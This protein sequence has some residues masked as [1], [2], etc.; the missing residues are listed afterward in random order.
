MTRVAITAAV[1]VMVASL[2]MSSVIQTGGWIATGVGAIIIVAAAGVLTRLPRLP[3]AVVATF[4]VLIALVPMLTRPGWPDRSAALVILVITALSATGARPFRGFAV[5]ASYV[6]A[7]LL[8]LNVTFAHAASYGYLIPSDNSIQALSRLWHAAF[9]EFQF[10]PPVQDLPAVS[11]VTAAGIGAVAIAVDILAVRLRR[12]AV[13]GLPLL[14]LFSVPVASNLKSF[15]VPQVIV[16]AASLASYLALLSA[17]GRER[18]RMWGRLV[19]FRHVQSADESGSGPDTRELSASGRRIGLAAVCL[20]IVIPVILPSMRVR[21]VFATSADGSGHSG[22]GSSAGLSPLLN[23]SHVLEGKPQPVL[24]YTT[25]AEDPSQQYF[26]VYAVNYS[27]RRNAWLPPSYQNFRTVNGRQLPWAAP[28]AGRTTTVSKVTTA[29][30]ISKDDTGYAV[31]PMPYAPHQLTVGDSGWRETAGT[32]MVFNPGMAMANLHYTVQSNE[33][34]PQA[35]EIKTAQPPADIAAQYGTYTGPD[36]K[37]LDA[38]AVRETRGAGTQLQEAQDLEKWFQSA[39]FKYSLKPNLPQTSWLLPFLNT[40]RRGFCVQFAQAFAIL[41]RVLG[42]PARI[43]IGYTGGSPGPGKTWEVT[44]ADAHAWPELYFYG[45]GWLRFEP[46]PSGSHGPGTAVQPVYAG[47]NSGGAGS[48]G[49]TTQPG[50][51]NGSQGQQGASGNHLRNIGR[52]VGLA[53]SGPASAPKRASSKLWLAI[54]IPAALFLLIAWPALTRLL[55][56]RRRWL[57][58]SGDAAIA[59]AA[60]REL[61]DDLADYGLGGMPGETPR[62]VARRVTRQARLDESAT[63]AVSMLAAAEERARYARLPDP[64]AGLKPAVVTVRRAVAASVPRQQRLRAR[65]LPASTMLAAR[66]LV[67]RVSE[68]LGWLDSSWPALQRQLRRTRQ[69]E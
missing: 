30:T 18:L 61:T 16:F 22:G 42:I 49:G 53:G 15:G 57:S 35:A 14:L 34:N 23:L 65:L 29:I 13:A 51:G 37:Q 41:A 28:G 32:L 52:D 21:D 69:A 20:A 6:A 10:A 7:L 43:A 40:V 56:R 9:A 45:Y 54:A 1:A 33:V 11:L 26:Q 68:M 31:L 27:G 62:A 67:Q 24:S 64:G 36:L 48:K 4:L 38:I 44:T 8:Y 59:D 17:D 46:T 47:G 55:T 5:L 66:L 2:S 3:A 25:T 58:A 60:W 63:K 39:K 19:T 12:P 50:S